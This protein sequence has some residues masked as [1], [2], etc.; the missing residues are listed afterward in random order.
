MW[1]ASIGG[2]L[3]FYDFVIFV[4]FTAVIGKLFFAA[5]LPDWVRQLQTFGIFAVG[6]IVRPLGGIV[7]AHPG[8]TLGRKRV[9]TL[10]ILLM[11]FPTLIIGL[12]PT[13]RSIGIGAPL[14]LLVMRVL[15][16][17]AIGG[18]APG[19]WVFVAEH[20]PAHRTGLGIGLLTS[21]LS[22]GIL[23]GSLVTT[24]MHL[25][26]SPEQI[27][28]GFW[29]LPF[30]LGGVLGFFGLILR[31]KLQET[32][33]FE[34]IRTQ[35]Q[36][37]R[38][39]PLWVILRTSPRAVV[40]S[41]AGTWVL[42]A[43]IL[44]V[45]LMTPTLLQNVFRLNADKIQIA[46]LAGTAALVVS[47]TVIGMAVDRYG[48]KRLAI[49]SMA[50]LA[51][52]TY[53]LYFAAMHA[54]GAILPLYI[55]A[56]FGA[57]AVVLTPIA[58]VNAFPPLVRFTGVSFS[59]NIAYAIFGGLTPPLVAWL[60]QLNSLGPVYYVAAVAVIGAVGILI[61]PNYVS[62][63]CELFP[64]QSLGVDTERRS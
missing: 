4:F 24:L 59:Y 39:L 20:A 30:L 43:G 41:F 16:G 18:E 27:L 6:Y 58:M 55:L 7:M 48:L 44:V 60:G 31:R 23:I 50:F 3:E 2:A 11:A 5:N 52:S 45:I 53:A 35:A 14:L 19:G 8:D 10:S 64:G 15:Q 46:N 47:T 62:N 56:G 26:L 57:G 32:P 54:P 12:V 28:A 34:E 13:Y 33:V 61:S 42:T 36:A 25:F 38:E 40:A 22:F 51:L 37:R 1:L 17:M 9:F 29:R 21:G 49:P 63:R